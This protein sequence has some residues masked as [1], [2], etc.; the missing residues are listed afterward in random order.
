[1]SSAKGLIAE[2]KKRHS[3]LRTCGP[4][5]KNLYDHDNHVVTMCLAHDLA[6]LLED[7]ES[8][9]EVPDFDGFY[10]V[11]SFGRVRSYRRDGGKADERH[12]EP[13]MLSPCPSN[14]YS[15]VTLRRGGKQRMYRVHSLVL[16]AFCGPRP[17][18]QESCH[19][20]GVRSDNR[21]SNLA[22]GTHKE[23][24]DQRDKH[25]GTPM[26]ESHGCAK[27]TERQVLEI[28]NLADDYT[29]AELGRRYGVTY[30]AIS[31]IV[32]G[33]KWKHL[34]DKPDLEAENKALRKRVQEL[35]EHQATAIGVLQDNQELRERVQGLE[36]PYNRLGLQSVDRKADHE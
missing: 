19:Q 11:S 13:K 34:L 3:E 24:M 12:A 10:E 26:G 36:D 2:A 5:G 14:G 27:L 8:W 4:K 29:H 35:E 31:F 20:N 23:N 15:V 18:G 17:D 25:G 30:H 1:M 32:A 6:C 7:A 16:T 33:K 21:L 28:R 22:W 9:A